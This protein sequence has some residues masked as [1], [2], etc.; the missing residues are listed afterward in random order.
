MTRRLLHL[1]SVLLLVGTLPPPKALAQGGVPTLIEPF[2]WGPNAGWRRRAAEVRT[3]RLEL[4]RSRNL[5]ALNAVRGGPFRTPSI[6]AQGALGTAVTGA[7]HLPVIVL[8]YKNIA[9]PH[10][11]S[12][13]ERILFSRNPGD[14]PYTV[15]TYYEELS[16]NRITMDGVVFPSTRMDSVAAFYTDGCNGI[17]VI[18]QTSCPGRSQNRMSI[19][20][21]A[22]L[23]SISN[24][25]GGDTIWSQFDNDGPDGIPNSGDDNG[26]V[27][28]VTFLQPEL[29]GECRSTIPT[30]T[31]VWS[32]RFVLSGWTGTKYTTKTARRGPNG[33]PLPGQFIQVDDYTIQSQVGGLT[34]CD[35]SQIMAVGTV[36]HETGHAFGLPDLYDTRGNTQGIGGWGLM[37]SGNYARPHSPSSFDAWSLSVLGWATIDTLGTSRTITTGARQLSDTIF[38][39]AS[40]NANEFLLVEN[41]QAVLSDTAHMNPSLPNTC[42]LLGFCAKSPGLLLW[43]IDQPQV[44]NS[45]STNQVNVGS[46]H[47]VA[48][49]QADGLNQ[50]RTNGLLNRGD[51]GDSYPG[52]SNN[53]AMTLLSVPS[54]LDNFGTYLGFTIDRIEQLAGTAMSFRFNR[55][56]PTLVR[57]N[58]DAQVRV[59]GASWN[60]F[61]EVVPGGDALQLGVDAEQ[62][63]AGGKTRARFVAWT[64]G[65]AKEQLFT[66]S[67]AKP[68]TL[69][70]TF[71]L[72]HRLIVTN[73]AGGTVT[74]SAPGNLGLGIF[75]AE[76]TAVTLTATPLPGFAF[77]GWAGDTVAVVG[78]IG[79]TMRKGYDLE[80]RFV[81]EIAIVAADAVAEL[82]G[83]PKL[84]EAQRAYL[85]QLGN[86]NGL[87]DVGDVLAMYRRLGQAAPPALAAVRAKEVKP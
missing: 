53:T 48:L 44:T 83:T 45:L 68:D 42:P 47:G 16:H 32:H 65:G 39:A 78:P 51:R 20:L 67:A 54:A 24:R 69:T 64:H 23:D 87:L 11:E 58:S 66:S 35:G 12:E 25:P 27:D 7:F 41:R 70:A 79:L 19:A 49:V 13:Y 8:A 37:G 56:K 74:A 2:D 76:N 75:L 57:T 1:T 33:Q 40:D 46:M 9:A 3:R 50:L 86:R 85:D 71:V 22:A 31:G 84:N 28:F 15:T 43:L 81:G 14:R 82:L 61:E 26:V 10:P 30:P 38:V 80:A 6:V 5:T 34:S 55:R 59:N 63:L 77:A 29:G 36:A 73:S 72:E 17:T 18:G 60:R 4:L 52:T 62:I 21:V